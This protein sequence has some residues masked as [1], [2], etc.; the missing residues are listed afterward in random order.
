VTRNFKPSIAL[1]VLLLS[2]PGGAFATSECREQG[3]VKVSPHCPLPDDLKIGD[4]IEIVVGSAISARRAIV[5]R[6]RCNGEAH[7]LTSTNTADCGWRRTITAYQRTDT[8]ANAMKA[9]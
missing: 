4:Q 1:L 8:A 6:G 9:P 5:A 2:S 7:Y 3:W